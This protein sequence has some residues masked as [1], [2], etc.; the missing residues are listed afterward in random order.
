MEMKKEGE[1]D[2]GKGPVDVI[3]CQNPGLRLS[4]FVRKS[5]GFIDSVTSEVLGGPTSRTEIKYAH[6]NRPV[7]DAQ[8]KVAIPTGFTVKDLPKP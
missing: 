2:F 3:K 8:L 6:T 7:S 1:L 4:I 5:D